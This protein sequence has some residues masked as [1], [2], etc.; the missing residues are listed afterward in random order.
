MHLPA[1][2][3][4]HAQRCRRGK[5]SG[6]SGESHTGYKW[7]ERTKRR[8]MGRAEGGAKKKPKQNNNNRKT[9][10]L[11]YDRWRMLSTGERERRRRRVARING[12]TEQQRR[13]EGCG[14]VGWGCGGGVSRLTGSP[15]V[16]GLPPPSVYR[17]PAETEGTTEL[18]TPPGPGLRTLI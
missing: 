13:G 4:T 2:L 14:A 6:L 3:Q 15:S 9:L 18:H 5:M 1:Q 16:L 8:R 10:K 7:N 17:C 12:E 11:Q